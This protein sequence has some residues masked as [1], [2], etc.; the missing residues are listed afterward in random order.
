MQPNLKSN[1]GMAYLSTLVRVED[2]IFNMFGHHTRSTK[3]VII[4]TDPKRVFGKLPSES[5]RFKLSNH[6]NSPGTLSFFTSGVDVM[7]ISQVLAI[8]RRK[9]K[10]NGQAPRD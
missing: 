8:E 5:F 10:W 6:E 3:K 1:C 7:E 2:T 4:L 9:E